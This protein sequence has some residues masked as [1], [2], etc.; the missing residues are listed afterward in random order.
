MIDGSP[1]ATAGPSRDPAVVG[2]VSAAAILRLVTAAH[3]GGGEGDATDAQLLRAADGAPFIP[4]ASLAG[5]CRAFL[6]GRPGVTLADLES[7]F[8]GREPGSDVATEWSQSALS[9]DDAFSVGDVGTALR[10]RV[11][12]DAGRRAAGRPTGEIGRAHV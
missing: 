3:F 9:I 10:D 2:R 6:R 4:G 8:G 1:V 11:R 5:A 7:L 12:I